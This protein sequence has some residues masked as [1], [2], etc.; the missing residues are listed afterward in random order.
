MKRMKLNQLLRG[1]LAVLLTTLFFGL[2]TS[3]SSDDDDDNSP[4]KKS[5]K[6]VFKAIA[7]SG[8][9][10]DVAVYG[11]DG[12][13]TTASSLSGTTWTSPEVTSEPGA[14]NAN[15]AVNAIGANA[16]STL[17]VQIWVDGELKKEGSSSGQYLSASASYV[18]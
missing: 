9:N 14:Y 15:V 2:V 1:T 10:I 6:V 17:K 18:F 13:P 11:I 8:S 16:S 7:S 3:C 12:N 4:A 5:H